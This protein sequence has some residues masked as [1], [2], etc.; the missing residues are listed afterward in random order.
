MYENI[1]VVRSFNILKKNEKKT[2]S[3]TKVLT[4]PLL[5]LIATHLQ[6]LYKTYKTIDHPCIDL[7]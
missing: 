2:H 6:H 5:L 3:N 7:A 1:R 4:T